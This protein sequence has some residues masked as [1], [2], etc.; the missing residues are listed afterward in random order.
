M[1]LNLLHKIT[2]S[3]IWG[4]GKRFT[5]HRTR[6]SK[7]PK[8]AAIAHCRIHFCHCQNKATIQSEIIFERGI[9]FPWNTIPYKCIYFLQRRDMKLNR[10]RSFDRAVGGLRGTRWTSANSSHWVKQ[11]L[12][13]A[14]RAA[15]LELV[16]WTVVDFQQRRKTQSDY[17]LVKTLWR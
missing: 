9:H 16:Y 14:E 4:Q 10:C 7:I 13:Q 5:K 15:S 11:T 2:N 1:D 17:H 8:Y 6:A 3:A 12:R